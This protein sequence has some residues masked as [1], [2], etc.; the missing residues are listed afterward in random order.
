MQGLIAFFSSLP[1]IIELLG[2]IG[3]L[4]QKLLEASQK[5]NINDWIDNV[6]KGIDDLSNAKTDNEKYDAAKKLLDSIRNLG[7]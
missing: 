7:N 6:E 2:R 1:A 5:N 4:F 3:I